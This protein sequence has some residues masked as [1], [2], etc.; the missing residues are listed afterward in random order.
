MQK[1]PAPNQ[2]AARIMLE[3]I[4]AANRRRRRAQRVG[5]FFLALAFLLPVAVFA[6]SWQFPVS[7]RSGRYAIGFERVVSYPHGNAGW[8]DWQNG[9]E[10]LVFDVSPGLGGGVYVVWWDRDR[11][12]PID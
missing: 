2:L 8:R 11:P 9:K 7:F 1:Q 4:E 3:G 10:A 12:P 5:T 6:W